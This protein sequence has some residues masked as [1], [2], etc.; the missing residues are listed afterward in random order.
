[1]RDLIIILGSSRYN[2]SKIKKN[3]FDKLKD[4][5][6]K[7]Q[8]FQ[9][10]F[11]ENNKYDLPILKNHTYYFLKGY[12]IEIFKTLKKLNNKIIYEPLDYH[13]ID[14]DYKE[15]F[16][17]LFK[18]VDHII[19]NNNFVKDLFNLNKK[20]TTIYHE[21]DTRFSLNNK[22]SDSL[23]Y[24]GTKNKVS[25]DDKTFKK[26]NIV[27]ITNFNSIIKNNICYRGIH[28][29][30]VLPDN[31]QY[32]IHTTT[33]LATALYSKSIFICNKIPLYLDILGDEYEFYFKDD[34]T[35]LDIIIKKAKNVIN[36]EVEYN[37]YLKTQSKYLNYFNP[38]TI[39]SKYYE[40]FKILC[41]SK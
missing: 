27:N 32:T 23:Y 30:F 10:K 12:N 28:L 16:D 29:D 1:M 36:N 40:L 3:L 26:Y 33:K 14:S 18:I 25:L 39:I 6:I 5:N 13:W 22:L 4:Y 19:F 34:L 9:F 11:Q 8:I 20:S 7:Y 24:I 35:D 31:N 37:N 17:Y 15:K 38:D 21:Y 2:S 41:E